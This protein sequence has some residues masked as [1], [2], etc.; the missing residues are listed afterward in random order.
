MD[1]RVNGG[2]GLVIAVAIG[3]GCA[4]RSQRVGGDDEAA[5]AMGGV[6]AAGGVG[7]A[8]VSTG[9]STPGGGGSGGTISVGGGAIH[10]GGSAGDGLGATGGA[11]V[12]GFAGVSFGEGGSAAGPPLTEPILF[13]SGSLRLSKRA[14]RRT[15]AELLGLAP[16]DTLARER[17]T[18][19]AGR[20]P[21]V[22]APAIPELTAIAISAVDAMD[23]TALW[24]VLGCVDA[25]RDCAEKISEE[26][27]PRAFRRPL[28]PAEREDV[29]AA[30]DAVIS[31]SPVKETVKYVLSSPNAHWIRAVGTANEFGAI[32]L[33]DYE[34]ASIL[35]YGLTNLPPDELLRFAADAGE[36]RDPLR[37]REEAHRLLQSAEGRLAFQEFIRDWFRIRDAGDLWFYADDPG[38][39]DAMLLE[40][41]RFITV[42]TY[43]DGAPVSELLAAPWSMLSAELVE[44]YGIITSSASALVDLS[45][46]R[47][48]GIVH[49]G[50][51]LASRSYEEHA[52][53]IGR[54]VAVL[55]LLC[56]PLV[57]PPIEVPPIPA[58]STGTYRERLSE[59]TANP[60]CQSCHHVLDPIAFSF[61][62]FDGYGAL[63]ELDNGAPIDSTGAVETFDG[64]SFT[65]EDSAD[66]AEQ[67]AHHPRFRECFNRRLATSFVGATELH[68]AATSYLEF[69]VS[70]GEVRSMIE[71]LLVWAESEHFV[72][73]APVP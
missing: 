55:T 65:F 4:G 35:S 44:H 21:K 60:A 30:Y 1:A 41:D 24:E 33:D 26:F 48:R 15:L 23:E 14:Y 19:E 6:G 51:F 49:H 27:A 25:G 45:A 61:G 3:L 29:L 18:L 20:D 17:L 13:E 22:G 63:V 39:A 32:T 52:G 38:L 42:A 2:L 68:P 54:S 73:R 50:S 5:G 43:E 8:S 57:E 67:I 71:D 59:A 53:L 66:L 62:K 34:V 31:A 58:P 12:A 9:G 7:G 40:T 10:A 37:R 64:L 28:E 69:H 46:T 56:E 70:D 47:R 72:R 16:D 36:L 11:A